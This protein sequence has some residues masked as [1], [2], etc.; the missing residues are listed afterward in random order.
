MM[1]LIEPSYASINL[2]DWVYVLF[3][4]LIIENKEKYNAYLYHG[5]S[6]KVVLGIPVRI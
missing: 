6:H 1:Q 3:I 5:V 2:A 4:V